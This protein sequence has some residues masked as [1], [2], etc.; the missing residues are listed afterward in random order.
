MGLVAAPARDLFSPASDSALNDSMKLW[1]L[2]S[3]SLF[4]LLL[5]IVGDFSCAEPYLFQGE[6]HKGG[7]RRAP[8]EDKGWGRGTK[9]INELLVGE[10]A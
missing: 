6:E 1:T 5:N 8:G 7:R 3:S 4:F 9:G 10:E 2:L